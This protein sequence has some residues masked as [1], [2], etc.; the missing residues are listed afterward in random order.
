[1]AYA[2]KV[3][4]RQS[5]WT[6]RRRARAEVSALPLVGLARAVTRASGCRAWLRWADYSG[7]WMRACG[8]MGRAVSLM[9]GVQARRRR[10]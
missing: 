3:F 6:A 4:R 9:R 7:A 10:P 2:K 8:G 1:M 5:W